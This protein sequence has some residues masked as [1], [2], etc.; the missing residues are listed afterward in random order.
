MDSYSK[1]SSNPNEL[2][3]V[4]NHNMVADVSIRNKRVSGNVNTEQYAE[5]LEK[6]DKKGLEYTAHAKKEQLTISTRASNIHDID[7]FGEDRNSESFW[8][9]H[10]RSKEDYYE[11]ASHIPEIQKRLDM[12]ENIENLYEHPIL[13]ACARCYFDPRDI[14]K[15]IQFKDT[16]ISQGG[17][18]HRILA[19]QDLGMNIFVKVV[20]VYE[21]IVNIE[22]TLEPNNQC[23]VPH[24]PSVENDKKKKEFS[25]VQ[26]V[27]MG[28]IL[29]WLLLMY[30]IASPS[31][32][33]QH[34]FW[35]ISVMIPFVPIVMLLRAVPSLR[36][37]KGG[38]LLLVLFAIL[39]LLIQKFYFWL[40]VA[41]MIGSALFLF[42]NFPNI[43]PNLYT[44]TL[45][46]EDGSI[47]TETHTLGNNIEQDIRSID[48]DYINRGY[49]KK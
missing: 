32:I 4:S 13:G 29:L 36:N 47:T 28:G 22:K 2:N 37:R 44:V 41:Y 39:L 11:L 5:Y 45:E 30:W 46:N 49:T 14:P 35:A 40:S 34:L 27:M 3:S 19:A 1:M 21:P 48:A 38:I 24:E 42:K 8:N 18:R 25:L 6:N 7:I 16:Y 9:Q 17:N 23:V 31:G 43:M 12:G 10:K 20:G 26:Y 33:L 15:V